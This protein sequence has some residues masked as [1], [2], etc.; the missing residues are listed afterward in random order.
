M[1]DLRIQA[2]IHCALCLQE[3]PAG[4]SPRDWGQLEVGFTAE[5]LQV[6]CKRHEANV[7]HIDFQGHQHPADTHRSAT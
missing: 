2:Y 1:A 5:G 4:T 7:M 3:R 6:W